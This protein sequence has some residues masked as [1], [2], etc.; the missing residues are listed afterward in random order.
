MRKVR[1]QN[2]SS[3]R[4]LDTAFC[5]RSLKVAL[6]TKTNYGFVISEIHCRIYGLHDS[7]SSACFV[8]KRK[9]KVLSIVHHVLVVH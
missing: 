3:S 1:F 8:Q 6:A 7:V 5:T 2:E 9:K 4:A